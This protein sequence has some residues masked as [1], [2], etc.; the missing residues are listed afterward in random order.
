MIVTAECLAISLA[1]SPR[2]RDSSY[3]V[4]ILSNLAIS[5]RVYV[6]V[7]AG[8]SGNDERRSTRVSFCV[9]LAIT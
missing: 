1:P 4:G 8:D 7:C 6:S 9:V 3:S 5:V 2:L